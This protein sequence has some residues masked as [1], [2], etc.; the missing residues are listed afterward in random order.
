MNP[1]YG[2]ALETMIKGWTRIDMLLALYDRTIENVQVAEAAYS[3]NESQTF[4]DAQIAA[5]Q[6]ILGLY[7][8]LDTKEE[9]AQ[10]VARLLHFV[11]GRLEEKDFAQAIKFLQRLRDSF[12]QVRDEANTLEQDGKIPAFNGN[13]SFD[14]TV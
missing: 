14:R 13:Y 5:S 12:A 7:E 2:D 1:Y 6:C 4:V 3:A 9:S 11:A 10:N 8:G